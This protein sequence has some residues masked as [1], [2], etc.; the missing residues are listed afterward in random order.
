MVLLTLLI[1]LP[2]EKD[3]FADCW[4]IE[5]PLFGKIASSNSWP[6]AIC[7]CGVILWRVLTRLELK[8]CATGLFLLVYPRHSSLNF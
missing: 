6:D 5:H 4:L 3:L 8:A 2:S 1:V 7:S